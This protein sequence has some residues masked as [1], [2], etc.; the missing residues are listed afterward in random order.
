ME[1][2][3]SLRVYGDYCDQMAMLRAAFNRVLNWADTA[4]SPEA[5]DIAAAVKQVFSTQC[6]RGFAAVNNLVEACESQSV[7]AAAAAAQR[8]HRLNR[9]NALIGQK[10]EG[11]I[12]EGRRGPDDYDDDW[13][14]VDMDP[15]ALSSDAS[16]F[17]DRVADM[18]VRCK[19]SAKDEN[20]SASARKMVR[21]ITGQLPV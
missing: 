20:A 7:D 5:A 2:A 16:G 9:H 18:V 19:Q 12:I 10:W 1:K 6:T 3:K 4:P 11:T 15:A 17:R 8:L 13:T 14:P 21:R